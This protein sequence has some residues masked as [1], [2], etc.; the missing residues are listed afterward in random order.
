MLLR[1]PSWL[2]AISVVNRSQYMLTTQP[3]SFSR[4][5]YAKNSSHTFQVQLICKSRCFAEWPI[6]AHFKPQPSAIIRSLK[7]SSLKSFCMAA[8]RRNLAKI[9]KCFA[10]SVCNIISMIIYLDIRNSLSGSSFMKLLFSS[11]SSLKVKAACI[12]SKQ[13]ISLYLIAIGSRLQIK[14]RF[15]SPGC[16]TS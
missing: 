4:S 1:K 14:N 8:L 10:I 16:P 11:A 2:L 6:S 9:S 3:L 15:V 13:L 5:P 12:F 7:S